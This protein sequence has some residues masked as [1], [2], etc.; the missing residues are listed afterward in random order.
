MTVFFL[1]LL[2]FKGSRLL[3]F[4]DVNHCVLQS[5]RKTPV[6]KLSDQ[7]LTI[8][9][10]ETTKFFLENDLKENLELPK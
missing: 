9:M 8:R 1:D 3:A 5:E 6:Y 2:L 4:V 10:I 7:I